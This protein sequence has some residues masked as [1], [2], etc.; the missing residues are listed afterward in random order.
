[1]TYPNN[2]FTFINSSDNYKSL[3]AKDLRKFKVIKSLRLSENFMVN[4]QKLHLVYIN[5]SKILNSIILCYIIRKLAIIG[6]FH[7]KHFSIIYYL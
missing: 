1:M 3:I 4:K 7:F 5:K 6:S 2:I